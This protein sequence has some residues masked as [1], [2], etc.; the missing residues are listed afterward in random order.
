MKETRFV[1][2]SLKFPTEVYYESEMPTI[3]EICDWQ[4]RLAKSHQI[5]WGI[6][7][8][9]DKSSF[10]ASYT[11]KG[12]LTTLPDPVIT[13]FGGSMLSAY[14][15]LYVMVEISGF[16]EHGEA[17]A[18]GALDALETTISKELMLILRK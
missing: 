12:G 8:N 7:Y 11:N 5:R 10:I 13:A 15:K 9:A 4:E 3:Q 18:R 6:S 16:N 2:L 1:N 14:Q 17:I